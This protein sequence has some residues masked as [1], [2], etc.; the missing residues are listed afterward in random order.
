MWLGI[1]PGGSSVSS[2]VITS[3]RHG[4]NARGSSLELTGAAR[5]WPAGRR[6]HCRRR[7]PC[8]GVRLW[9]LARSGPGRLSLVLRRRALRRRH[10]DERRPGLCVR[11]R[12]GG[13]ARRADAPQPPAGC[14]ARA[15]GAARLP[16]HRPHLRR[17]ARAGPILPRPASPIA[18]AVWTGLGA[19]RGRRVVE[20]SA[21]HLWNHRRVPRCRVGGQGRRRRCGVGPRDAD[22]PLPLPGRT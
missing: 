19:G 10:P 22:R 1:A 18:T 13:D 7:R 16:A 21:V 20:G 15:P 11:R 14:G 17:A 3:A 2:C 12:P 8:R 5:W 6:A 4:P 9:V